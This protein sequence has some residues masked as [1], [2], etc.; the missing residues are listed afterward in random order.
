MSSRGASR[1]LTCTAYGYNG[2]IS[3]LY[4]STLGRATWGSAGKHPYSQWRF[5]EIATAPNVHVFLIIVSKEVNT[6]M[7]PRNDIIVMWYTK[8][9]FDYRVQLRSQAFILI[10]IRQI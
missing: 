2:A 10:D 1:G 3:Q 6:N 8:S 4:S 7:V 9:V 5:R